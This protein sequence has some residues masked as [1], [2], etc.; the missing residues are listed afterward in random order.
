WVLVLDAGRQ[1]AAGTPE[2]IVA[3]MPGTVVEATVR[4]AGPESDRSWRHGARW[5]TWCPP[6]PAD[7]GPRGRIDGQADAAELV[8][9]D[10]QD[11][12]TVAALARE[13]STQPAAPDSQ[14]WVPRSY[15]SSGSN[16]APMNAA[17][18]LLAE[19]AHVTCRFGRVTAVNDV[20][21]GVQPGEI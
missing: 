14:S 7:H 2:Q 10:L 17:A 18:Q 15:R 8:T 6:P 11:A 4:P 5:R 21:I 16:S 12:V 1:I 13:L 19:T 9:P 20:S 3:A